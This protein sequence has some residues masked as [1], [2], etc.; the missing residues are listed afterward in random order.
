LGG[1][2]LQSTSP[3]INRGVTP[4]NTLAAAIVDFFGDS[5]PKGGKYDIGADEVM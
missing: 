3:L 1:Y 5:T 2:K 4:P